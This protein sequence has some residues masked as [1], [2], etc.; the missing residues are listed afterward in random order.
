L[1][2]YTEKKAAERGKSFAR[3]VWETLIVAA[4]C[5]VVI[6]VVACLVGAKP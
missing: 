3:Q 1:S 5:G 4:V 6:A 2:T